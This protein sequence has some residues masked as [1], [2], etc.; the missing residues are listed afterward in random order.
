VAFESA[1]TGL[2]KRR[3]PAVDQRSQGTPI[4]V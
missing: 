2:K 3:L 1:D 4:M